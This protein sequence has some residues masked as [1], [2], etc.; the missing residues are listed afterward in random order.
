MYHKSLTFSASLACFEYNFEFAEPDSF[1]GMKGINVTD[2]PPKT[3]QD[4]IPEVPEPEEEVIDVTFLDRALAFAALIYPYSLFVDKIQEL[5][6]EHISR[7]VNNI[8]V[9]VSLVVFLIVVNRLAKLIYS[10]RTRKRGSDQ[11]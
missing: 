5:L 6:Y 9:M 2:E 8:I 4:K 1:T 10:I 11:I 7:S 3:D